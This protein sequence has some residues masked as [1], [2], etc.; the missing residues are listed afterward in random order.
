VTPLVVDVV[1]LAPLE[2][3]L[4]PGTL[5]C[6]AAPSGV[7]TI[8][9]SCV[10]VCLWDSRQRL[11]GMN[12]FVLPRPRGDDAPSPRF[13]DVAS[14]ALVEQM[15]WLGCRIG[16]LRAKLFGGAAVLPFA[17]GG[18]PVGAQ[19]VR[20]AIETLRDHGIPVIA[21]RGL[22]HTSATRYLKTAGGRDGLNVPPAVVGEDGEVGR[23]YIAVMQLAGRYSYAGREW[24]VEW[25]RQVIDGGVIDMVHNHHNRAWHE[26][27][28]GRD[29][30]VVRKG[31]TTAFP[32]QRGF[33]GGFYERPRGH[34]GRRGRAGGARVAVL[35]GVRCRAIVRPAGRRWTRCG[36]SA[37]VLHPGAGLDE[38]PMA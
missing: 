15:L 1:T 30:W 12:H 31:A 21:L 26:T 36:K 34:P 16:S 32:G 37:A 2:V 38:G 5:H 19:N 17:L 6:A 8:L 14:V 24:V 33:I 11:G 29:V 27:H 10:A 9:G 28:D 13:G 18:H 3:F 25:V 7:T 35:H 4:S 20:L 23:R 22:G